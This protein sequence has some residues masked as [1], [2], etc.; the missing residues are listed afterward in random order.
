MSRAADWS[1][2]FYIDENGRSP[3]REFLAG[4]DP[5]SQ[6]RFVFLHGFQKKTQKTPRREIETAQRRLEH[7]LLLGGGA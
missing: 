4:L 5:K 3:V 6:V 2:V 7:F 1:V